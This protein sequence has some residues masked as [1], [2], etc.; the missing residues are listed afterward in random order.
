MLGGSINGETPISNVWAP[1]N[2]EIY[3]T[4]SGWSEQ[5]WNIERSNNNLTVTHP[6]RKPVLFGSATALNNSNLFTTPFTGKTAS[7]MSIQ[8]SLDDSSVK[9]NAITGINTGGATSGAAYV[10]I[11]FF[12]EQY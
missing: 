2:V 4:Q 9:F 11:T 1:G 8:N 3:N 6:L 5:D 12:V 10:I 7:T